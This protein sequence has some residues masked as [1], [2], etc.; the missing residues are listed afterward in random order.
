MVGTITDPLAPAETVSPSPIASTPIGLIIVIA[1]VAALD[2]SVSC[3]LATIPE[4]IVLMF[5]PVSR[6]VNEPC[7]EAQDILLPAAVAAGPAYA[8]MA[9]IWLE[10]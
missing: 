2:A 10:G 8:A 6:Q 5:N 1:V 3:T 4:A 7:A 9:E